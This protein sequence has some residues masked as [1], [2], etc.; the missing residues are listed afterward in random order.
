MMRALASERPRSCRSGTIYEMA[1]RLL[2][3]AA[4][5]N[6]NKINVARRTSF[7]LQSTKKSRFVLS[8]DY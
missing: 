2:C 6:G 1:S 5:D 8:K 7:R 3:R 4:H